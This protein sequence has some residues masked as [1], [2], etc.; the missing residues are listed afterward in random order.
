MRLALAFVAV[1]TIAGP[2]FAGSAEGFFVR[3][4]KYPLLANII[5]TEGAASYAG[6]FT[7]GHPGDPER[8]GGTFAATGKTEGANK[9]VFSG[10]NN[11]GETCHVTMSY[12][13]SFTSA[14]MT[15]EGCSFYHGVSC[16][17]EGPVKRMG[18]K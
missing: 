10:G 7:T 3:E 17:F 2:A 6:R 11:S 9:I 1:V 18:S 16:D 13:K 15:S 14:I 12:D 5:E 8:C 4:G